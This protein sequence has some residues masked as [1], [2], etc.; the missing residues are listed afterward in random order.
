MNEPSVFYSIGYRD[1]LA[2]ILTQNK[3]KIK[4]PEEA[5]LYKE[6]AQEEHFSHKW[7]TS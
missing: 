4:L 7:H 6:I 2:D 3:D 5:Q 1:C